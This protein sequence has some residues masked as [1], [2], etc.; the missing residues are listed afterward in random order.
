MNHTFTLI[1]EGPNPLA[2]A[3]LD[4]LFEGGCDDATFGERDG[5]CVAEFDR[6]AA[7]FSEALVS[8]I[9]D[10]EA[11]VPGLRAIRVEPG[12]LVT[13]SEIAVR[14][15]RTRESIRQLF[16][17]VRGAGEFPHPAAWLSDRTRLWRW[18]EVVDWFV[19]HYNDWTIDK[20]EPHSVEMANAI[21]TLRNSLVHMD[22]HKG[23]RDETDLRNEF[24]V[25]MA[26]KQ[27]LIE[28]VESKESEF[29]AYTLC[30]FV[31]HR[32]EETGKTH[33]IPLVI[34]G[35]NTDQ[36]PSF[37]WLVPKAGVDPAGLTS[38]P[39]YSE[40]LRDPRSYF[41]FKLRKY[42]HKTGSVKRGLEMFIDTH[43]E[44][45]AF[46]NVVELGDT[47][48]TRPLEIELTSPA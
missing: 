18:A 21:L 17:G 48:L 26:L 29:E 15:G 38:D 35:L 14:T 20:S 36:E 13:A 39:Y 3:N 42:I 10:V 4:A 31:A 41:T 2:G 23:Q 33:A 6:E 37:V 40:V 27:K 47:A 45:L 12:D 19:K 16:E 1:L 5:V 11:A 46:S 7:T 28:R 30:S 32:R 22:S 43:R 44:H 24:R 9:E 25:L 8:A 34:I